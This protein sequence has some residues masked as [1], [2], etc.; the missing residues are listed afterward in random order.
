MTANDFNF[1]FDLV[2]LLREKAVE[3][4]N[5]ANTGS[6]YEKGRHFAYYEVLSLIQQQAQAFGIGMENIGMKEFDPDRDVL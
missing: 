4:K 1:L 6:D 5:E 2:S 3:A